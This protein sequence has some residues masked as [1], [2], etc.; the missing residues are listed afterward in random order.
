MATNTPRLSG[1]PFGRS[2]ESPVRST[3][4]ERARLDFAER[5]R[6]AVGMR[7]AALVR[8]F[9]AVPREHFVG[10]GPWKILVPPDLLAYRDTPDGD[11]RHL[12]DNVLVALDASR[13]LINGEPAALA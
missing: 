2:R 1:K 6:Q 3:D 11:A 12:Y 8:A 5:L 7:S 13:R 10:P 9:A 4:L